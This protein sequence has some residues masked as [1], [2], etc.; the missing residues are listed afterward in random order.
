MNS[1]RK[2]AVSVVGVAALALLSHGVARAQQAD[3]GYPPFAL[4][5]ASTSD[6][7]GTSSLFQFVFAGRTVTLPTFHLFPARPATPG[8]YSSPLTG[9]AG[10]WRAR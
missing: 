1:L 5:P 3:P 9:L 6:Q 4:K 8:A 10:L 7:T 2:V